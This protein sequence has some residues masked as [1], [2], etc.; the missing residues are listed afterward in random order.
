MQI[1]QRGRPS[2][3]V[4]TK[5]RYVLPDAS[6]FSP[7]TET[8]YK[9]FES[10]KISRETVDAFRIMSDS[11]G[12]IVFPFYENDKLVFVKYRAPRKHPKGEPFKEWRDKD[13]KSILF[14][15]D[16]VSFNEEVI[17]TEGQMD[18]MALYEAGFKNVLSVPSGGMDN[19]WI[20]N[21]YDA[22]QRF[23]SILLFGD[24]D[25]A[26]RAA[27]EEWAERL[28][29]S[30]CRIVTDYPPRPSDPTKA[31]KDANEVWFFYGKEKLKEMM[32]TA[33][34]TEMKGLVDITTIPLHDPLVSKLIPSSLF[35]INYE[36]GG[37]APGDLV[38]WTGKT[39]EGKTT[40]VSQEILAAIENGEKV[41][42]YNGEIKDRKV[43]RSIVM[44]AAGSD[45]VG[46]A[47]DARRSRSVPVV[48]DEVARRVDEW[49]AGKLLLCSDTVAGFFFD[50][51]YLIELF[52]YSRRRL[53]CTVAVVDNI[54]MALMNAPPDEY[55]FAQERFT[56]TLKSI[57]KSMDM[58]IH[59]VAH[60]RKKEGVLNTTDDVS[61]SAS[62]TRLCDINLSVSHG[63][64][65]ILKDRNEGVRDTEIP[66]IYYPDIKGVTDFTR[67]E[68]LYCSWDRDGIV[69][70]FPN[71]ASEYPKIIP[72]IGGMPI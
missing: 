54:M 44:Q 8:I 17:I 68:Q 45:Y 22:L 38:V 71:A 46:L 24:N 55:Y 9:F 29:K 39:G 3:T 37:Y 18:A 1:Q 15:L 48:S 11:D 35:T 49:L 69:K 32:D 36:I 47:Y 60:P 20:D 40:V 23:P 59:L 62:I 34:E 16:M 64:V 31:T 67:D 53:G 57:A 10:R 51:E 33:E 14:G 12:N 72:N 70:P 7:P 26:G 50:T 66:F 61:G 58:V 4:K 21:C 56:M 27:V 5:K 42:W 13:T 43:H 63:S 41:V 19:E 30:R 28:D 65:R 25:P 6:R 52:K 2:Q